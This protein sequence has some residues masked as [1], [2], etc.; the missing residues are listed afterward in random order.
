MSTSWLTGGLFF[1]VAAV[2]AYFQVITV[3]FTGGRHSNFFAIAVLGGVENFAAGGTNLCL[4]TGGGIDIGGMTLGGC[5]NHATDGTELRIGAGGSSAGGVTLGGYFLIG[6]VVAA[7]TGDVGI[8]AIFGTGGCLCLVGNFVVAKGSNVLGLFMAA[9]IETGKGFYAL[10][11]TGGSLGL[12]AIVP[13]VS[14]CGDISELILLTADGTFIISIAC[15]FTGGC[16]GLYDLVAGGILIVMSGGG[17]LVCNL[18]LTDIVTDTVIDYAACLG[19][20][21]VLAGDLIALFVAKSGN[22]FLCNEYFITDG[23]VGAFSETG[24]GTGGGNCCIYDSS[25][26]KFFHKYIC[27]TH[28]SLVG[29]T[30]C[31]GACLVTELIQ[32]YSI[33]MGAALTGIFFLAQALTGSFSDF[34]R[35]VV[36]KGGSNLDTTHST[37]LVCGTGGCVTGSMAQSRNDEIVNLCLR[38]NSAYSSVFFGIVY[39]L[40]EGA[41]EV[42]LITNLCT[43]GL[44]RHSAYSAGIFCIGIL[45]VTPQAIDVL[46]GAFAMSTIT[47]A[48]DSI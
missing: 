45:M 23:A 24:G 41:L 4:S 17:N 11:I 39:T 15:L 21:G 26:A 44:R 19:T 43:S 30:G 9:V 8:P 18:F 25:M 35:V 22:L 34:L 1:L 13:L 47:V 36:A 42:S 2:L 29:C 7:G 6:A 27:T 16:L 10:I 46:I 38:S 33:S 12:D 14:G 28:A 37:G 20:G 48:S 31:S 3:F 32:F 5:E 40:T